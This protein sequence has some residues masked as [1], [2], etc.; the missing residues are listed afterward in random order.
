MELTHKVKGFNHFNI[1]FFFLFLGDFPSSCDF[2]DC[3]TFDVSPEVRQTVLGIDVELSDEDQATT[4]AELW[5]EDQ[6]KAILIL[7]VEGDVSPT[8]EF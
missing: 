6:P 4:Q 8:C 7:I 1:R 5:A 3:R 2:C